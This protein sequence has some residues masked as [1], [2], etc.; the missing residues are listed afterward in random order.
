VIN[1]TDIELVKEGDHVAFKLVY[2]KSIAYVYSIVNRYVYN[3]SDQPDVIQEIYARVFLSIASFEP[4][5]GAFKYWLRRIVVNQCIKHY[6][7]RKK[8]DNLVVP[9][10]AAAYELEAED[11]KILSRLSR[12]DIENLLSEMPEGYRQVF[13]L[14][15]LDE[16]HHKEV[17]ELLEISEE[18]SRSQLS[19][20]KKWIRNKLLTNKQ[21]ILTGEI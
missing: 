5:K 7:E 4:D 11:T 6:K 20:A 10:D 12:A 14:V 2:Q 3:D 8:S 19:R 15:V 17:G 1:N 18:T 16:Y 13:M 9:R 21:K